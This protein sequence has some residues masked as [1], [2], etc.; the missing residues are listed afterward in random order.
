MR[1]RYV[2][3][4]LIMAGQIN[5]FRDNIALTFVYEWAKDWHEVG[6]NGSNLDNERI[7]VFKVHVL[8]LMKVQ[9]SKK[10]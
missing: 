6:V 2:C 10:R 4:V 7:F 9:V 5:T 1:A 8:I 3:E